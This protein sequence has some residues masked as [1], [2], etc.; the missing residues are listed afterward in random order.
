V[1]LDKFWAFLGLEFISSGGCKRDILELDSTKFSDGRVEVLNT[2]LN[3]L[4]QK[5]LTG[6]RS[7]WILVDF[8]TFEKFCFLVFGFGSFTYFF[9]GRLLG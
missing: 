9:L 6:S 1:V 3:G 7:L 4:D 5:L 8:I 2:E